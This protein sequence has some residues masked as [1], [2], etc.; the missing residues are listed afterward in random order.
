MSPTT[1]TAAGM[2]CLPMLALGSCTW[3]G[4]D[5]EQ[6]LRLAVP[7]DV[8]ADPAADGDGVYRELI[9]AWEEENPGWEVEVTELSPEADDQRS[10]LVVAMQSQEPHYDVVWLDNQWI[11]EFAEQ[12]WLSPVDTGDPELEWSRFLERA[13]DAVCYRDQSWAVP[14]HLD[15]GLLYYRADWVDVGELAALTEAGELDWEKLLE[16]ARAVRDEAG[17]EY[18]YTAQLADYEG[19]TVNA[20]EFVL[21]G[22]GDGLFQSENA[23]EGCPADTS[24]AEDFSGLETLAE[25]LRS[26]G[27]EDPVIPPEALNEAEAES[28]NR[29]H[30]GE[31]AFMRHW[32]YA[33]EELQAD[34]EGSEEGM[35]W[36]GW[37][38]TAEDDEPS[39]GVSLLPT[40]VLG[41][42][43]LAV[44]TES[45]HPEEAWSLTRTMTD[46]AA[47]ELLR[48]AGLVPAAQ[49]SVC[50]VR[51]SVV[52]MEYW[53]G[54]CTALRAGELRPR[55]PYYPQVSDVFR[56][57]VHA[58]LERPRG[59]PIDTGAMV[60]ELDCVLAG[61]SVRC[62]G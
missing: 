18:G 50:G 54:L 26:D 8:T 22:D 36:V 23:E 38:G 28:L 62:E 27:R 25:E 35:R 57:H 6:V 2:L 45:E 29:F 4:G 60:H 47:Q 43:G 59:T 44:S 3:S 5:R 51:G 14:F 58:W 20:L 39:F 16:L 55:T 12:G 31:V 9:S 10:Q 48:E 56:G 1:K 37:S 52:E 19:L 17:A 40:A 24:T 61:K 49:S 21:D 42:N 15:V 41:G 33:I 11:P 32:P 53:A 30:Q 7:V 13:E 46:D 34:P